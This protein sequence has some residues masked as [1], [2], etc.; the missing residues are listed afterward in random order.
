MYSVPFSTGHKRPREGSEVVL[1]PGE[2]EVDVVMFE[3]PGATGTPDE[4]PDMAG[5]DL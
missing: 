1:N 4:E 2:V 3:D 5:A